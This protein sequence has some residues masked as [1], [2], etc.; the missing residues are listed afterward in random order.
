[1]VH[2]RIQ[3]PAFVAQSIVEI[4][5]ACRDLACHVKSQGRDI[6]QL[7]DRLS[8]L[9]AL[10]ASIMSRKHE[11]ERGLVQNS[12]FSQKSNE[13]KVLDTTISDIDAK[14]SNF[15]KKYAKITRRHLPSSTNDAIFLIEELK[16]LR[17]KVL[18]FNFLKLAKLSRDIAKM[19]AQAD[20]VLNRLNPDHMICKRLE[21]NQERFG[22]VDGE[23]L[24]H[25][26]V[27]LDRLNPDH[28]ICK[29]LEMNRER[30]GD[31]DG[32]DL[33]FY[34]VYVDE[35]LK[36]LCENGGR[37]GI[38]GGFGTTFVMRK[39][40]NR[41]IEMRSF[42]GSDTSLEMDYV[43]WA[44]YPSEEGGEEEV[45]EKLQNEIMGQLSIDHEAST[46]KHVNEASTSKHVNGDKIS[47]FL[48][49]KKYILLV[50]KVIH[51]IDLGR[52]GLR[53]HHE[54]RRL[55]VAS[56]DRDVMSMVEHYFE[57]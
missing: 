7:E 31:V 9:I 44:E 20:V 43:I 36:H 26:V 56:G 4:Y 5:P 16:K 37:V 2:F 39:V 21:M 15:I 10:M 35:V 38:L 11:L 34:N 41:L 24:A 18:T 42:S 45:I 28:M 27:V 54:F 57:I 32:E 55:V 12:A 46:S 49:H 19:S 8:E 29:R 53:G 1:M 17:S 30:F 3:A 51:G 25:A 47:A 50:D 48:R 40:Y 6:K 14:C 33:A 22:A 13:F 52:I 23:D